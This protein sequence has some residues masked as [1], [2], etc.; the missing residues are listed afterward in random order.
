MEKDNLVRILDEL[1]EGVTLVAVSKTRPKEDVDEAAKYG[2]T[3]FGENHV[4]EIE[5]KYDPRYSWHMIG[6][7]Q[8][9]KVKNVVPLASMIE[10]LDSMRLAKEIN[11]ECAKIDKVM[12]VLVEINI[13]REENKTGILIEEC[14]GFIKECEDLK[15]IDVQGLMCVGPLLEKE[16]TADCF[17]EVKSLFDKLQGVYGKEKIKYLSMGMSG[18]YKIALENGS[19]MVRLGSVIFGKRD[20]SKK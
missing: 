11:K 13:S 14:E 17:K 9:N 6:H 16:K 1:P 19:N 15:N 8:R 18:D 2:V 7:L 3:T 20:Y 5:A 10:S 12:P 4:Q